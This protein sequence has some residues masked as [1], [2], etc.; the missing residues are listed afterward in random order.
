M[1]AAILMMITLPIVHYVLSV[2]AR[3]I[4]FGFEEMSLLSHYLCKLHNGTILSVMSPFLVTRK[5]RTITYFLCSL[6]FVI[7]DTHVCSV[8]GFQ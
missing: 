4:F 2:M 7:T 1:A 5:F 8:N 6:R 3:L